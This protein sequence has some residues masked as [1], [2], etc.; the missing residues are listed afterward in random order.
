MS[1]YSESEDRAKAKDGTYTLYTGRF[2]NLVYLIDDEFTTMIIR[3]AFVTKD[4]E[5]SDYL[6]V[7]AEHHKVQVF[8]IDDLKGWMELA[9]VTSSDHPRP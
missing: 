8:C 1:K 7:F 5:D 2:N 4:P 3:S 6:W 9:E